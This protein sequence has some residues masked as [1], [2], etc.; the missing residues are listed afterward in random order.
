MKRKVCI[1]T[2]TSAEYGLLY[3]LMKEIQADADPQLQ[4]IATGIHLSPEFGLTYRQIEK[5][6]FKIDKN[7]LIRNQP[8]KFIPL[9]CSKGAPEGIQPGPNRKSAIPNPKS[10]MS[11][12]ERTFQDVRLHFGD[13]LGEARRRYRH[14]VKQGVDQGKRPDLQGGGLVRSSGGEK[15]GL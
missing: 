10:E 14:F 7:P 8:N 6:G 11:L 12:A 4:I 3:W 2:G 13:N 5:D 15:A 9:N 1:I